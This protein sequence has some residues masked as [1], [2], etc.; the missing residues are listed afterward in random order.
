LAI[1]LGAGSARGFA[2]IGVLKALSQ[3]DI[4]PDLVIGVSAGALVGAFYAAGFTPWQIEEV[5]LRV[6]DIDVADFSSG[7]KRGMLAG[8]S[9]QK[10]V[11]EYLK[12]MRIEQM[13][14]RF[15]AV[16]TQLSDGSAVVMQS[17]DTG[18]AVRASCAI[19]GVFVPPVINGQ[20][21]IDGSISS[22]LPVKR[23]RTMGT[24]F[25]LAVNVGTNPKRPAG[26]GLYELIMQSFDIMAFS[27]SSLEAQ[28][29]DFLI[30]PDTSA[31]S[32]SDFSVRKEMI[33]VGYEATQKALPELRKKLAGERLR[34]TIPKG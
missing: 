23:T 5:A 8:E 18:L 34:R 26:A 6:R 25:V 4:R 31:Y 1:V 10:L 2:H 28:S 33:Q 7:S 3:A 22:P 32:G 17:G 16:A 29:A 27:L 15:G 21:M 30:A 24:D 12:G 11:N 14:T 20:E 13:R 19:P 9:L